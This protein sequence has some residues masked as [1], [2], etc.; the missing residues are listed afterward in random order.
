MLSI[1]K[2][3]GFDDAIISWVHNGRLNRREMKLFGLMIEQLPIKSEFGRDETVSEYLA[4]LDAELATGLNHLPGLDV[5]YSEGLEDYCVSFIMQGKSVRRLTWLAISPPN[6]STCRKT[7]I[8]R[9]KTQ[10]MSR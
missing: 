9:S 6:S 3:T 5:I 7:I 2:L 10:S 4:A 8:R 1:A